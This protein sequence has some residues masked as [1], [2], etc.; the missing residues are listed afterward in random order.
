MFIYSMRFTGNR[1]AAVRATPRVI[2]IN[3]ATM[4]QVET[5]GDVVELL[6]ALPSH[7]HNYSCNGD[8]FRVNATGRTYS[9]GLELEDILEAVQEDGRWRI[10]E[11]RVRED[12]LDDLG[13]GAAH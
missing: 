13:D 3:A 4:G 5:Y 11:R 9:I 12:L 10:E 8:W 6:Q 1:P 7:D 2:L